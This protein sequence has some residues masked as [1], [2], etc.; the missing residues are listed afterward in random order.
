MKRF[1]PGNCFYVNDRREQHACR[2]DQHRP[3]LIATL[4]AAA[5]RRR[6]ERANV[7][8]GVDDGALVVGDAETA[9]H[10]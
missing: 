7:F 9:A 8:A 10:V 6:H 4:E 3:G 5:A 1:A 2:A